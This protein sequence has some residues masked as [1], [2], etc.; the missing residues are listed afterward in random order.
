MSGDGGADVRNAV[1]VA[2]YAGEASVAIAATQLG[3]AYSD[4][5]KRQVVEEWIDFFG[6]GPTPIRSLR[7]TTRTPKRLFDSLSGQPQLTSLQVKWGDYD[8]LTVLGGMSRLESL[9]LAGASKV[10]RLTPLAGF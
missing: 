8:D 10:H 6:S 5:Q 2:D 7:F 3:S 1:E 4:R 9:R